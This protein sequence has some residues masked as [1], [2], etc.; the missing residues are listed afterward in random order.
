MS[1][2]VDHHNTEETRENHLVLPLLKPNVL[3]QFT[4]ALDS[5]QAP[6]PYIMSTE[7]KKK[8][9]NVAVVG[10]G[11]LSQVCATTDS[12]PSTELTPLDR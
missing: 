4:P 8:M 2:N 1:S 11:E 5:D 10:C 3:L 6:I 12:V 7:E 9:I